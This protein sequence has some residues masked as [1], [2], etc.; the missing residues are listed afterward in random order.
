MIPSNKIWITMK[1]GGIS[2]KLIGTRMWPFVRGGLALG[3]LF[4]SLMFEFSFTEN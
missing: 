4:N 2:G 1:K 3:E